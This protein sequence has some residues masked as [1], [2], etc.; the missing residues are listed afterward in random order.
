MTC[1][2][3]L[4]SITGCTEKVGE[5]LAWELGA[6]L[7]EINGDS[8]ESGVLGR[9]F[10]GLSALLA[11]GFTCDVPDQPWE[12]SDL[13]ILGAPVWNG[14]AARPLRQWLES[15]PALPDRVAFLLTSEETEYPARAIEDLSSLTGRQ[16]VAVL[17]VS[18]ADISRGTWKGRLEHFL[19]QC[20]V[21]YRH[22]A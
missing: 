7:H 3:L 18:E 20:V 12:R 11:R 22:S 16:P 21:R 6:Q 8:R 10:S 19:D 4:Y 1:R 13:L 5:E 2:I 17:H 14:R 9:L 15:D